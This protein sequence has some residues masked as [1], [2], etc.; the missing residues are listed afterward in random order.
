MKG[1]AWDVMIILKEDN[2]Y[3]IELISFDGD[4]A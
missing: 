1:T 4:L 3:S 2:G